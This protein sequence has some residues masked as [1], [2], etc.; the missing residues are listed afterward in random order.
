MRTSEKRL[1]L[2]AREF[3]ELTGISVQTLAN[4]RYRD[5]KEGRKYPKPG[6]PFYRRIG[7]VIRYRRDPEF[8]EPQD[9]ANGAVLS[10][11]MNT[12]DDTAA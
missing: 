1:W 4:W 8:G 12:E 7:G 11:D 9:Y 10:G 2:S 3:S 6:F 5:R